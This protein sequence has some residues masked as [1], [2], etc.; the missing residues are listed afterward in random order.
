MNRD[1][2]K[3]FFDGREQ[4]EAEPRS[5]TGTRAT[6]ATRSAR[7]RPSSHLEVDVRAFVAQ[8][9]AS[10]ACHASQVSDSSF[11]LSM[12]DD[13]VRWPFGTEWFIER[14]AEPGLRQGWLFG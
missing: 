2:M 4:G 5:R 11:F 9:R 14:G 3:R 12:P 1:A 8:K 7:P 6:T 13:G 10:I